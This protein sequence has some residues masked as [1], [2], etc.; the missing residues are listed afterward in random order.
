MNRRQSLEKGILSPPGTFLT[1]SPSPSVQHSPRLQSSPSQSPFQQDVLLVTNNSQHFINTFNTTQEQD[2]KSGTPNRRLSLNHLNSN[3]GTIV[4]RPSPS[5]SPASLTSSSTII[6]NEFNTTL[7]GSN[8]ISLNSKKSKRTP[9]NNTNQYVGSAST[10]SPKA[11]KKTMGLLGSPTASPSPSPTLNSQQIVQPF[12][13]LNANN[14]IV[15]MQQP[16][17]SQRHSIL[18]TSNNQSNVYSHSNNSL[19]GSVKQNKTPQQILPKPTVSSTSTGS[20][21]SIISG[22]GNSSI[23]TSATSTKQI[24]TQSKMAILHQSGQGQ[25]FQSPPHQSQTLITSSPVGNSSSPSP[26]PHQVSQSGSIILPSGAQPLLLNQM[27]VLVQQNTPQGV[28]LILR[29][30]S[31][32]QL[33]TPSL[34]IHNRPSPIQQHQPQQLLRILNTNG[35]MQLATATATPTFIVSSQANLIHQNLQTI[36]TPTSA[37][38]QISQPQLIHQSQQQTVGQR[39]QPQQI[40]N[41][42]MLGQSVAQIQNLQINGNLTQIQMSNG[43]NS[44]FIQQL[45]AQFQQNIGPFNHIQPIG[46]QLTAAF[47]SPSH[48]STQN[49]IVPT[50]VIPTSTGTHMQFATSQ[51]NTISLTSQGNEMISPVATPQPQIIQTEHSMMSMSPPNSIAF[52]PQPQTAV[53]LTNDKTIHDIPT[54]SQQ[55]TLNYPIIH[56]QSE[57]M[58]LD[59]SQHHQENN[60][61][62]TTK[63]TRKT[64]KSKK[65]KMLDQQNQQQQPQLD[66][67]SNTQRSEIIMSPARNSQVPTGKLD[68]ANVIKLCGIMED[69]DFMDTEETPQQIENVENKIVDQRQGMTLQST[70]DVNVGENNQTDIMITFP[71]GSSDQPFTFTIPSSSLENSDAMQNDNGKLNQNNLPFMIRFDTSDVQNIGQPYTISIPSNFTESHQSLDDNK[72]VE[73]A[74]SVPISISTNNVSSAMCVPTFVNSVLS[75]SVT[76]TIQ[77]Q[78]NEIQ[79]QLMALPPVATGTKVVA[80]KAQRQRKQSSKKSKKQLEKTIEVPTQIGNIQISQIDSSAVKSSSTIGNKNINN[81]IQIMPIL[82][83]SHHAS[84]SAYDG[85]HSQVAEKHKVQVPIIQ[86]T[87]S[88]PNNNNSNQQQNN[89]HRDHHHHHHHHQSSANAQSNSGPS[90]VNINVQ[91]N[92]LINVTNNLQMQ[93]IANPQQHTSGATPAHAPPPPSAASTSSAASSSS[94]SSSSVSSGGAHQNHNNVATSQSLSTQNLIGNIINAQQQQQQPQTGNIIIQGGAFNNQQQSNLPASIQVNIQNQTIANNIIT[95]APVNQSHITNNNQQ[96]HLQPTAQNILSQLT[97]NLVLSLSEDGRLILRHDPN[98]PQDAQSQMILQTILTAPQIFNNVIQTHSMPTSH[99]IQSNPQQHTVGKIERTNPQNHSQNVV[100][101]NPNILKFVELPKIQ[102]NQQLFSL[103]TITN[104]ITQLNP[105][106]T[107]AALSPMERLLIVPSGINAQ[108]LAQ[109]LSQGQIHFNNIGQ[110]PSTDLN[111]GQQKQQ[112]QQLKTSG[113][114]KVFNSNQTVKKEPLE[115][116]IKKSRGKKAKLLEEKIKNDIMIKKESTSFQVQ[117]PPPMKAITTCDDTKVIVKTNTIP[118]STVTT[119]TM[120]SNGKNTIT[121]SPNPSLMMSATTKMNATKSSPYGGNIQKNNTKHQSSISVIPATS[122]TSSSLMRPNLTKTEKIKLTLAPQLSPLTQ[123]QQQQ[124]IPPPLVSVNQAPMPRVQTIQLTPQK[125]QSLKNIQMQIQQLS[126]KLQNKNLLGTLT[127]DVDPNSPVHNNPLPVLNNINAMSDGDIY[128]A[129]QRLFVEQQKILATGKIIPTIPAASSSQVVSNTTN[130]GSR[131]ISG[132]NSSQQNVVPITTISSIGS[133]SQFSNISQKLHTASIVKQEPITTLSNLQQPPP[134]VVSSPVQVQVKTELALSPTPTTTTTASSLTGSIVISPKYSTNCIKNSSESYQ[135]KELNLPKE[136]KKEDDLNSVTSD[137]NMNSTVSEKLSTS[138]TSVSTAENQ[139]KNAL[140]IEA[141]RVMKVTR[142]SLFERQIFVDQEGCVRPDYNTDF[143]SK[144]NAVK[145]LI[146]YHCLYEEVKDEYDSKEEYE[147]EEQAKMFLNSYKEMQKK[148]KTL[149]LKQS[150][151]NAPTSELMM[152]DRLRVAD[153]KD[154]IVSMQADLNTSLFDYQQHHERVAV[155]NEMS[156]ADPTQSSSNTATIVN[157]HSTQV[158]HI[159]STS[160]NE[161]SSNQLLATAS[162]HQ[163]AQK[164]VHNPNSHNVAI[165]QEPS[166]ILKAKHEQKLLETIKN[167]KMVKIE[168]PFDV[169]RKNSKVNPASN[170]FSTNS[171]T[172]CNH[173]SSLLSQISPNGS[174]QQQQHIQIISDIAPSSSSTTISTFSHGSKTNHN[175]HSKIQNKQQQTQ[176]QMEP[177]KNENTGDTSTYDEWLVIQKELNMHLVQPSTST[178]SNRSCNKKETATKCPK[179]VLSKTIESDLSDIFEQNA[180]PK[181]VEKQLDDLFSSTNKSSDLLAASSPLSDYFHVDTSHLGEK[182]VENRLE[183]LF[184]ETDVINTSPKLSNAQ[185]LVETRLEQ[186]FQGS[187]AENDESALDNASFLYKNAEMTYEMI[188]KQVHI[189]TS[190]SETSNTNASNVN[191][192]QWSGNCDIYTPTSTSMLF[193]PSSSTST[194]STSMSKRACTAPTNVSFDNKWIDESFDFASEIIST[195]S[196]IDESIKN[197]SWNNGEIDHRSEAMISGIQSPHQQNQYHLEANDLITHQQQQHSRH[198]IDQQQ[199]Q[200]QIQH[201]ITTIINRQENHIEKNL[202]YDEVD[203]ISRQVQNAI[204][205]ILNLQSTDPL[206]Y[207]LDSSFLE[208]NTITAPSGAP[209]SPVQQISQSHLNLLPLNH[210]SQYQLHRN[211]HDDMTQVGFSNKQ[212]TT[213]LSKRKYSRMDDIGDCLIGGT[214]LDDSPSALTITEPTGSESSSTNV[215]EFVNSLLNCEEKSISS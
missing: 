168:P 178:G 103:N 152:L 191:K 22:S 102:P 212:T 19:S 159:I 93:V 33:A 209:N 77:S 182:T 41:S 198:T 12:P 211:D 215:G 151:Q 169:Q 130:I 105:N 20:N 207:Q 23:M 111:K 47:Q 8:N 71:G 1:P 121:I 7:V 120:N 125:Q 76:P 135:Q 82:D 132:V 183:A 72:M 174:L 64:K 202:N 175:W 113:I 205:S 15:F 158:E 46:S 51:Q 95:T 52:N 44:Q 164:Y 10:C 154:E 25:S 49:E 118:T 3:T 127:A 56:H 199:H 37:T 100:L 86:Q 117:S 173:P 91:Q 50:A 27:P 143:I 129:L 210:L 114:S 147:F 16:S 85:K 31:A 200:H 134:L 84:S 128:N 29:P 96:Q 88:N 5:Q 124:A 166:Q 43:L 170:G 141:N 53:I 54:S 35:A 116:K 179:D 67:Q 138:T 75:T 157:H 189:S 181:S 115:Q 70:P 176:H 142:S 180:S 78:I 184:R 36:K 197:R 192:R 9:Q 188:Q 156:I 148:Y 80:A 177:I 108:Q 32:P 153:L 68:L 6:G 63:P 98:I 160:K 55:T 42:H 213:N 146:R 149:L 87:I 74:A 155:K 187:V 65:Q 48:T 145:R 14:S 185:D 24:V 190:S 144:N 21:S 61:I 62:V 208:L 196:T 30:P 18:Q 136:C 119:T 40:L 17:Q 58:T 131:V 92:Q 59:V 26:Q 214:N 126:A 204:D 2:R 172:T 165:M 203:D 137:N 99:V 162:N 83:K 139:N 13:I 186:L 104:E 161:S 109:C 60:L 94:A 122:A 66:Q 107:T 57:V 79:N 11:S 28:Q 34:V 171:T 101:Q 150:Q 195:E 206:H 97:G 140:A 38:T 39:Q 90:Q 133:S 73:S 69:D 167:E 81:Q 112:Q 45:P 4:Y 194:S 123:Q 106:Q 163:N 110:A 89:Q 193:T 201:P